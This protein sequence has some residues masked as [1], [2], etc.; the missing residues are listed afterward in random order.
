[1]AV[2]QSRDEHF[3]GGIDN[4]RL[5]ADLVFGILPHVGDPGSFGADRHPAQ[6][7]ARVNVQQSAVDHRQVGELLCEGNPHQLPNIFF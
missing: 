7:L 5:G 3:P 2:D 1:M 4:F 6:H